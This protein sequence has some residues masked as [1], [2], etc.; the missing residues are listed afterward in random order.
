M[1]RIIFQWIIH[2]LTA[3]RVNDFASLLRKWTSRATS[4]KPESKKKTQIVK[5]HPEQVDAR[6]DDHQHGAEGHAFQVNDHPEQVDDRAEDS[7]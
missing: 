5:G 6:A 7:L 4:R 3:L 1:L 2:F